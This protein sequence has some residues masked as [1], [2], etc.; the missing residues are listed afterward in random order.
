[1][2]LNVKLFK[3][4]VLLSPSGLPVSTDKYGSS[5]LFYLIFFKTETLRTLW[6]PEIVELFDSL[7]KYDN[8][9]QYSDIQWNWDISALITLL[10]TADSVIG[11]PFL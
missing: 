11:K 4:I 10:V 2:T 9:L 8:I 5:V 3:Y 6:Q 7:C 1:M